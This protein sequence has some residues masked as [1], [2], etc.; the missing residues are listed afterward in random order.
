MADL[1]DSFFEGVKIIYENNL[2]GGGGEG[3]EFIPKNNCCR[4]K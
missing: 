1:T 3:G 2:W 4:V